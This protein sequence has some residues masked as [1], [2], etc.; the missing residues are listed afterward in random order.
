MARGR[1]TLQTGCLLAK[2]AA[3]E[4]AQAP[5]WLIDQLRARWRGEPVASLRLATG[6]IAWRDARR[7]VTRPADQPE[8]A[9]P[10]AAGEVHIAR[11]ACV[12]P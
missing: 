6:W 11:R 3:I 4:K 10:L 8:L 1:S 12:A 7:T 9:E 5:E 2:S